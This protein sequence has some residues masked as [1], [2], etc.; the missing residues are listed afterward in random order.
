[1]KTFIQFISENS[2]NKSIET[3]SKPVG[4]HHV[5]NKIHIS[6]HD[7]RVDYHYGT[8][9]IHT[10]H[11]DYKNPTKHHLSVASRKT[12]SLYQKHKASSA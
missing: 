10:Q 7:D 6:F 5:I 8:K 1:M 9:L 3:M 4:K 12:G 11:G 2:Y